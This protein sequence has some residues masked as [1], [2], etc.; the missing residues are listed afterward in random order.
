MIR[1]LTTAAT[2]T[3][4]V[5]AALGALLGPGDLVVLAGDLGAGKTTLAKGIARGLGVEEP[6]TS[7]TFAIV[8][9]YDGRVP[10]AH[11]DVYRLVTFGELEDLALDELLEDHVVLVEWGDAVSDALP[12]D[13]L[14]VRLGLG[15][16]RDERSITVVAVGRAW[17]ERRP[18]LE[19]AF[20]GEP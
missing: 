3:E 5:G 18:A 15:P 8:Q 11:A 10:V 9:Q 12:S 2:A 20:G 19:R 14:E 7:P 13:R 17:S 6:V 4:N 1:T 16:G